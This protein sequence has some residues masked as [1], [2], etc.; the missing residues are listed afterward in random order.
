MSF[1]TCPGVTW[2][3][4]VT[5]MFLS[6]MALGAPTANS[7][8]MLL[9]TNLP[10]TRG[11][12][13]TILVILSNIGKGIGPLIAAAMIIS[14][15]RDMAFTVITIVFS[16]ASITYFLTACT[17]VAEEEEE[18]VVVVVVVEER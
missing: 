17:C 13:V 14:L 8:A 7:R 16:L 5:L 6:G 12:A 3:I 2:G 9:N 11:T 1:T 10:E 15:G 18:V 4:L